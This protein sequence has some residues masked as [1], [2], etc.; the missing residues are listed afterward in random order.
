MKKIT[1]ITIALIQ[2]T[3]SLSQLTLTRAVG[4]PSEIK[5]GMGIK[6]NDGSSLMRE[7]ITLNE[8]SCPLQLSNNGID[9]VY[10]SSNYSSSGYSFK[11]VGAINALEPITAYEIVHVLYDVFGEHMKSLSHTAV[12]DLDGQN[13]FSKYSSWYA[14]E[15][16][17]SKYLICVSY[18]SNVRLKNGKIWKYNLPSVIEELAKIEISFEEEYIPKNADD[19]KD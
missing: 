17:V 14:S 2:S 9:A 5:L 10:A 15:N 8:K 1:L 13:A 4:S 12:T 7:H 11:P 18:V 16:D 3:I 19:K 6:V